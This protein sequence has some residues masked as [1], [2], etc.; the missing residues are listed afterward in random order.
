M[1]ANIKVFKLW[2]DG[3]TPEL[4]NNFCEYVQNQTWF[5]YFDTKI[6]TQGEKLYIYLNARG[7]QV[8][9]NENFKAVLLSGLK[10]DG[11]KNT[12]GEKWETWQDYFW[13]MRGGSENSDD[14]FNSFVFCICW[15]FSWIPIFLPKEHEYL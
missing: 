1:L 15:S 4:L 11:S 10:D 12:W 7:E 2:L 6:S 3:K 13:I 9:S 14:G 8:Q 5:W